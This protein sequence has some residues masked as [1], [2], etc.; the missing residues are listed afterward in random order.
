MTA[1]LLDLPSRPRSGPSPSAQPGGR[2]LTLE[3]RLQSAWRGLQAQGVAQ[4]PVCGGRMTAGA[5]GGECGGCDA[6]LS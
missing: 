2:R 6:R 3:E 5:G 4:C 1:T